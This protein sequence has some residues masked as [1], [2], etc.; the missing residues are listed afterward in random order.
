[1]GDDGYEGAARLTVGNATFG[2]EVTLRG[3]FQPIDGLF[4]W[5]GRIAPHEQLHA[6]LE[7]RRTPATL[8][9][10]E[11]E[12]A[13]ELSDPDTWGRYRIMGTGKPPFRVTAAATACTP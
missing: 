7:G 6:P 3:V 10:P 12:A 2:V 5:Y 1:M 8:T 11:G 4:H 9:T 13:G